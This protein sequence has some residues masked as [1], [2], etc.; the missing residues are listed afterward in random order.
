MGVAHKSPAMVTQTASDS[1]RNGAADEP[2]APYYGRE[3]RSS[4]LAATLHPP[5]MGS[6]ARTMMS[7]ALRIMVIPSA[8][9]GLSRAQGQ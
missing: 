9:L 8:S 2:P 5:A 4:E 7:P 6:P 1:M 3:T